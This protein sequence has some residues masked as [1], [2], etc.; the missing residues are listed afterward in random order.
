MYPYAVFVGLLI[1]FVALNVVVHFRLVTGRPIYLSSVF[2]FGVTD[3][4]MIV[5]G[6]AVGGGFDNYFFYLLY[7]PCLAWFA[8]FFSS[9]TLTFAW[10]TIGAAA[11]A[12]VSIAAGSGLDLEELQD[13][14]LIARIYVMF[15]VVASVNLIARAERMRK[16]EAVRRERELQRDRMELSQTMHDTTAQSVYMIDLGIQTGLELADKGNQELVGKLEATSKLAKS[17]MW[18]LRHPIDTGLIFEGKELSE[19]LKGHAATFTAITSIPAEV[20]QTGTE[21]PLSPGRRSM[22]FS[23]AHNALTNALRHSRATEVSIALDFK[24]TG[25]QISVSDNG[26]GLP[27]DYAERGRGFKCMRVNAERLGGRLAV[28]SGSCGRGTTVT[29]EIEYAPTRGGGRLA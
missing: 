25:L 5:I 20:V 6:T 15:V 26:I 27:D 19:A 12:I 16:E 8:V 4:I 13:K 21:P 1:V 22:L 28:A 9:F 2:V 29:C 18:E 17:A 14:T 23:I 3:V 7:Y 11:Y 10:V 24:D